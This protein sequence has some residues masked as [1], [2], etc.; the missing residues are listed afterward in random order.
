MK[1]TRAAFLAALLLGWGGVLLPAVRQVR[2]TAERAAIY[3]EPN[4]SSSRVDIVSKGMVL[5]LFQ[6][7]KV[8]NIWYYVSYTSVR[9]GGRLSGFILESAVEPISEDG[10]AAEK[11]VPPAPEAESKEKLQGG[12]AAA[13]KKSPVAPAAA[14]QKTPSSASPK[15]EVPKE[16]PQVLEYSE[17]MILTRAPRAARISLPRR[18]TALQDDT[19][20]VVEPVPPPPAAKMEPP[21]SPKAPTPELAKPAVM[22]TL[23]A[24]QKAESNP[25]A[26][27]PPKPD[28]P[29]ETP[30]VFEPSITTVITRLP[31]PSRVTLPRRAAALQDKPWA[32]LAPP[33]PGPEKPPAEPTPPP[34][35]SVPKPDLA[36]EKTKVVPPPAAPRGDSP[37]AKRPPSREKPAGKEPEEPRAVPVASP[38]GPQVRPP[39]PTRPPTGGRRPA[40]L[41]I[42]LGYGSSFG[43]AGGSLQVYLSRN[44]ALHGGFGVY[45]TTVVYSDTDWV[46][47]ETLWSAGLR[48]YPAPGSEK[49]AP[50]LDAQYGG[51]TVEA[52]QVITGIYNYSFLFRHE[53]K[54]LWGPSLLGG[55][56]IRFNRLVLNGGLGIS[57]SLTDWDVL[58]RRVFFAFEAGLGVRL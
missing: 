5:N 33:A 3:V 48:W 21:E 53:Q 9:Y 47:N 23:P 34:P 30:K 58:D 37:T 26:S 16:K 15:P 38:P 25:P 17:V 10:G 41:S 46:K 55:L 12:P 28:I 7:Q 39:Q 2:V 56:E 22:E 49:L 36:K 44:L 14:A 11:P 51:L 57:Y 4:R 45:P 52:A 32:V 8:K 20:A 54:A 50:Y 35:A 40:R 19:W 27:L 29:K 43:G 18:A 13:A 1:K 6:Q 42:S 31:R 24:P